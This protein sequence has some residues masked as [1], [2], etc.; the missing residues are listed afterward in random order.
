MI[1]PR[2][3]AAFLLPVAAHAATATPAG[4]TDNLHTTATVN[5]SWVEN[6]SR[7]SYEPTRKDVAVYALDLGVTQ[8]RQLA[9]AWLLHSGLAATYQHEPEY[10]LN[11]FITLGPRVSVQRKFG[12]GPYA[13]V[14]Q[15]DASL[16]YQDARYSGQNG[17]TTVASLHAA[18]RFTAGLR[19]AAF[20]E[21]R[22][23]SARSWVFDIE[24]RTVGLE[25]SWD[26]SSR[27]RLTGR[28]A[29]LTGNIVANAAPGIWAQAISGGF[30]ATVFDYYT[31][32]PQEATGLY[33]PG[34]VS[35]T[36]SAE[37]DL[38]SVALACQLA[39]ATSLEFSVANAYVVNRINIRYPTR[40][41]GL[42]LTHRF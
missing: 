7:T 41:W 5:A 20:A 19:A 31:T 33:G 11:D 12:L 8:A 36:V 25:A 35:Y 23:H 2:L 17:F 6:A 22:E 3:L 9:P 15:A 24:Q 27:W 32:I 37:V 14:L 26:F 21:W 29:R 39:P 40:T 4:W 18:K 13:P 38:W 16:A 30:G 10:P 1:T 28:A 42:H 34:W